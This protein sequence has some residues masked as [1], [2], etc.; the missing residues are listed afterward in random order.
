[1][2]NYNLHDYAKL[3]VKSMQILDIDPKDIPQSNKISIIEG[4][5]PD[6]E[7]VVDNLE[8]INEPMLLL[9]V[10]LPPDESGDLTP[11]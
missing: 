2:S 8:N 9:W 4:P 10:G 5:C 11:A 6:F 7:R 3:L 1:M